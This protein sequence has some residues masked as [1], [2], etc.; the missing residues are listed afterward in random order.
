MNRNA[1]FGFQFSS[2]R[3][4]T[5]AHGLHSKKQEEKLQIVRINF[6]PENASAL[7]LRARVLKMSSGSVADHKI[8]E[9]KNISHVIALLKIW[10]PSG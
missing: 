6:F 8:T 7:Q 2:A 4:Y 3:K 5:K 9:K 1:I 10:P